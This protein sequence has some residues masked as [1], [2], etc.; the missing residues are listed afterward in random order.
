[1]HKFSILD[2]NKKL[3][4][5]TVYDFQ[6]NWDKTSV[7][8]AIKNSNDKLPPFVLS[9]IEIHP[10]G[11]CNQSCKICYGNRLAPKKRE[12]LS[13]RYINSLLRDIKKNMPKENPLIILSGLYSEP[14]T[15]PQIK[16]ILGDIGKY[17]FRSGLYTNGLLL[18]DEIMDILL[19]N[20]LNMPHSPSFISFN[21]TSSLLSGDFERLVSIIK[22]LSGRRTSK[23]N[24]Q[25]NAPILIIKPNYGY[26]KKITT[27]LIIAG[28]DVIRLSIPWPQFTCERKQKGKIS[29]NQDYQKIYDLIERL[30]KD[31]PDK[32]KVR[33]N[34]PCKS[35][36]H[37]YVMAMTSAISS[38]GDIYPCPET[39]SPFFKHLSY[40]NIKKDKFSEVWHG[41]KHQEVFKILNSQNNC[42]K[43]CP[44]DA[45]FNEFCEKQEPI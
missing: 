20:S 36:K 33:H 45:M 38:E 23:T 6:N 17:R 34:Q 9:K 26:I 3:E 7:S 21:V 22:R 27:K 24:L 16:E 29:Q 28:V 44:V 32:I 10:S 31:F 14:L 13:A 40:G 41:I 42:C 37:C 8:E 43:C 15:N 25:I 19:K 4:E 18:D 12:N 1:M 2:K 5:C 35:F 11:K 39:C 30:Q